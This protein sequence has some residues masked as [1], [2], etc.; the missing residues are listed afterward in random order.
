[1]GVNPVLNCAGLLQ[2]FAPRDGREKFNANDVRSFCSETV[3]SPSNDAEAQAAV[4]RYLDKNNVTAVLFAPDDVHKAWR[5]AAPR[6]DSVLH[7]VGGNVNAMRTAFMNG[8]AVVGEVAQQYTGISPDHVTLEGYWDMAEQ[9]D[10]PIGIHMGLGA[11]AAAYVG[12]TG[13]LASLSNP[14]LLE[15]VL[16]AHPRLRLYIIHAAWPMLD[17]LIAL[18]YSHPQVYVDT[19]LIDWSIP[20]KEFYTYLKRLVEAGFGN[21]VMYASHAFLFPGALEVGLDA[22]QQ[23]PFLTEAQK[24]DILYN[25]AARFLR[26]QPPKP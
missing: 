22:I 12:Q 15:P 13:Y 9:L 16:R 26:L 25:N 3:S 2:E 18:M 20:R 23:A 5:A 6:P 19:G 14:L 1:M 4:F 8:G 21:R 11:P 7:G 17:A 10:R 24:R